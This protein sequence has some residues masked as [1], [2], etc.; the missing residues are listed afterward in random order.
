MIPFPPGRSLSGPGQVRCHVFD[1]T[2]I[3]F[4]F[5]G[6]TASGCSPSAMSG[7]LDTFTTPVSPGPYRRAPVAAFE[8]NNPAERTTA[9]TAERTARCPPLL[10]AG[11]G[12]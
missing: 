1:T 5:R 12:A 3:W 6:F 10:I 7:E 8:E 2:T 4:G 11:L 9:I